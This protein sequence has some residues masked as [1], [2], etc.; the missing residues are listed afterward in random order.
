MRILPSMLAAACT[1]DFD[2]R[3]FSIFYR[4]RRNYR[5]YLRGLLSNLDRDGRAY[6]AALLCRNVVAR[7]EAP[8]MKAR[9]AQLEN[10]LAMMGQMLPGS[11]A[12]R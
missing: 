8:K 7:M 12:G 4:A 5:P 11:R 10:D 6:L 9:L 3:M 1:G 2:A